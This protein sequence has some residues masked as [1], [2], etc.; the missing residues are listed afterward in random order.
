M[1]TR[2]V[3]SV[4]LVY[5]DDRLNLTPCLDAVF[6]TLAGIPFE[7]IMADNASTDGGPADAA[8]AFPSLRV[9]R[10]PDNPGF[11][12]AN[13][14]AVRES[15]GEFLL[16]LNTDTI[17]RPGAVPALL[18]ALRDDPAAAA[19]GP[20][21]FPAEG[22]VQ[23]SFGRRVDF[24][25][26]FVQKL[27]LNPYYKRVLRRNPKSR[28]TGWLSAACLLCRRSAFETAGGFD[29]RFFLYFED[30][31]LCS[32]MRASGGRLLFVPKARV[33]HEGGATTGV[34]P[35]ASRFAYRK[36]Q[37][38]YYAKHAS[39]GS[40]FLLRV[41]LRA[42]LVLGKALGRFR[43]EKGRALLSDYRDLLNSRRPPA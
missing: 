36:S 35:A 6:S 26:Q 43:G 42:S 4:I 19:A 29:E 20:L 37:M 22:R 40:L 39:R 1:T 13:N 27:L 15:S 17:L 30:I 25:G 33:F 23:V 31:D 38:L 7:A 21:L 11:G 9:L 8:A 14:R 32:R 3:L 10:N 18:A 28:R 41:Y 2:P 5:F 16:F 12:A 34:R 24:L